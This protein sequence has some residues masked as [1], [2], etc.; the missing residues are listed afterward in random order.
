MKCSECINYSQH[1]LCQRSDQNI[2]KFLSAFWPRINY[3][4]R[5]TYFSRVLKFLGC[6]NFW[7]A[8]SSWLS[9]RPARCMHM[10][11]DAWCAHDVMPAMH[12]TWCERCDVHDM[13]RCDAC[14][15][16][17]HCWYHIASHCAS[18]IMHITSQ[19]SHRVCRGHHIVHI[20]SCACRET[21]WNNKR[22]GKCNLFWAR[23]VLKFFKYSDHF[24]GTEYA[25]N[26]LCLNIFHFRISIE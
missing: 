9:P 8:Y 21:P 15:G 5:G 17:L 25:G 6:Q 23:K 16:C 7:G 12:E 11:Q 2:W 3:I 19:A 4:F 20:T 14:D 18:C 1:I 13:M 22:P 10:M 24:S 26:S